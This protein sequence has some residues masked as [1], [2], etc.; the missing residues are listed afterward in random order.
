MRWKDRW[1]PN[2]E[3]VVLLALVA[4]IGLFTAIAPRFSSITNVVEIL[5]LSVELGLLAVA[6]TPVVIS[7]GIDL[8][9]GAMM[10]LAAVTFGAAYHDWRLPIAA[11]AAG[12]LLVG[13][14][15]GL[16]NAF[17]IAR[18]GL[19]P[20]IVTLG[21]LSVFRG[22]AEGVT[23]AAVNYTDFPSAF[24]QLGQGYLWGVV[25]AQLPVLVIAFVCYYLLLHRS[26][27]G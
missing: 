15:G 23:Q 13:A 3:W 6:L 4:E 24:L 7:G 18:L 8:S 27:L 1:S 12:A 19:A 14:L 25:P 17:L 11:A 21:S 26:V 22:I 16:L 9:V 2:G 5:R 10:G 20:L